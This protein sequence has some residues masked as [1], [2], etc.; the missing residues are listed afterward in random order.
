V[1]SKIVLDAG[2][3]GKISH[4]RPNRQIADWLERL[5]TEGAVVYIPEI[6]D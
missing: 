1:A 2:P 5:L 4:P 6:A 3:L